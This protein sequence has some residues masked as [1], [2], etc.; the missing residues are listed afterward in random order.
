MKVRVEIHIFSIRE[1]LLESSED[2]LHAFLDELPSAISTANTAH[3]SIRDRRSVESLFAAEASFGKAKCALHVDFPL[4][5][6]RHSDR[7]FCLHRS[8]RTQIEMQANIS[9]TKQPLLKA[10][11]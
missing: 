3:T 5:L 10:S 7:V 8:L 2:V 1:A 4:A 11:L 9:D 6:R